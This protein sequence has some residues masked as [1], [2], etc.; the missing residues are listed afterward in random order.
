MRGSGHKDLAATAKAGFLYPRSYVS[1]DGREYRLGE[2][3]KIMRE[4]VWQRDGG[5]CVKCGELLRLGRAEINHKRHRS[6]GGDDRKGNL[7]TLCGV[8]CHRGSRY[9]EHA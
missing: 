9:A 4:I 7:E 3:W 6:Q 5:R 8:P 2:D 1:T